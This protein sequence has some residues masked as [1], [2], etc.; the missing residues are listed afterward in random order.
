MVS[1]FI[2]RVYGICIRKGHVLLSDELYNGM[3]MTKFPGGGLEYGEGTI[4]CLKREF[5]EEAVGEIRAVDHYYTTDF[6]QPALFFEAAQ[7]LSVYYRVEIHAFNDFPMSETVLNTSTS[8]PQKLRWASLAHLNSEA[9][10]FPIDR[11]VAH[12]LKTQFRS[13]GH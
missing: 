10:T 2:I 12:R 8:E 5:E 6:F 1:N 7:L 13:F 3:Q 11:L 9:L 4:D